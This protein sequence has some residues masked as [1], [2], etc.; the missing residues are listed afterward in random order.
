MKIIHFEIKKM[1]PLTNEEYESYLNKI[2]FHSCK[3]KVEHKYT[4]EKK[5]IYS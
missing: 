5:L 3:K 1:I 4:H 2:N